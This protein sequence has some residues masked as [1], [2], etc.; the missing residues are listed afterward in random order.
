MIII[1]IKTDYLS[2]LVVV[3]NNEFFL[4]PCH[5]I[6]DDLCTIRCSCLSILSVNV[7]V[8]FFVFGLKANILKNF[9][10]VVTC[11]FC[12]CNCSLCPPR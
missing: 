2:F 5:G 1:F 4:L 6:S 8:F 10:F 7:H 12:L 11:G 9:A 3:V